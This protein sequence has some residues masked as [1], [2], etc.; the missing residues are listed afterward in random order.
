MSSFRCASL[1]A[2]ILI[3]TSLACSGGVVQPADQLEFFES[4]IRPVFVEH[5]YSCHSDKAEK[6]KGGLR[7]DSSEALLKG[8]SSGPAIVPGDPDASL[9]IKAVRYKDPDLQMPP[10]DKKLSDAQIASLEAW[11]KMGA[12]LPRPATT[13]PRPLTDVS[14]ARAR[15]WAFQPVTKP[16]PPAVKHSTWV[17]TPIDNFG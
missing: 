7:L 14:E 10:K 15:H 1:V 2:T 8:G 6:L 16:A 12:P 3:G 9:L 5:C 4:K 11:V 13:G 17:R